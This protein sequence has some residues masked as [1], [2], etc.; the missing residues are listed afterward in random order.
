[1][2]LGTSDDADHGAFLQHTQVHKLSG[3]HELTGVV[4]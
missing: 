1:M 2:V 3:I 4:C